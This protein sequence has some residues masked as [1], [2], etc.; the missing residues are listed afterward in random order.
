MNG[1]HALRESTDRVDLAIG[2]MTCASCAA[3]V[4][5]ALG[6]VPG[7]DECSVNFATETATVHY[8]PDAVDPAALRDAVVGIGYSAAVPDHDHHAPGITGGE[9]AE[10]LHADDARDLLRRLV[11]AVVLTVPTVLIS[12]VPALMFDGWQWVAG[13]LATPVVF[14]CGWPYHRATWKHLRHGAVTMDTLV[15]VGTLS[16]WTWS[17]VALLFLGAGSDSSSGMAGM[18]GTA[19]SGSDAHVYFETAAAITALLLL[20]RWFEARAKRRS[21]E[22][23]RAL[24]ELGAKTA[25]LESGEEIPVA[26]LQVGQRFVV[27]PGEK[28]AT[29]GTV[30]TGSSAVDVSMLTGESVPEEVTEGD[31]VFGA[32]VNRS[33]RLVVEATSVGADT[34]LAQ[35]ARLVAEA[36]GS[37]A[38]VQRLADRVSAVFVPVVLVLAV[39]TLLGWLVTGHAAS[40]AFTAAVAVLII[41]CPCALGLATPTAIMVGTGR[42][43]QLGILIKG[44][45]VLETSR[46]IDIAVLDKTGTITTGRMTLVGK[47]YADGADPV[48][49][50]ALIAAAEDASEHP[51]AR[52]VVAGLRTDAPLATPTAVASTPG[53]G[54]AATVD[55]AAVRV[56]RADHVPPVPADLAAAADAGAARGETPVFGAVDGTTVAVFLVADTPK[57]HSREAVASL[58]A[59]GVETVML[60]GDRRATAEAVARDVGVDRVI[61]EV[62]P[63]GKVATVA[64][65]QAAGRRVAMVGDG[66][67][68][69]PALAQSDLG[70]AIGAGTDVAI[71]AGDVT[72]V[73]GDLR[74]VPDAIAL[75]R[76]TL[77]TI[78]GNLFWAFAYN[79]AA[80]PLAAFGLL[81]PVIAAAAMGFSSVFVVTNSL[82]LRRFR[83]AR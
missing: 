17:V 22:A 13:V 43:A 48:R 53:L 57:E 46:L 66:V 35:I 18:A 60:T 47:R 42:G 77:R 10:H 52:A 31:E 62:L 70:I 44:G 63:A 38:P 41:A 21:S 75:S 27:R 80:I 79:V 6:G 34:A 49:T 82:R 8:H 71:E 65:L 83:G 45:E 9:H 73:S 37:K 58:R 24:V 67:N 28:I 3:R 68:D 7:V 30:V 33:G 36:Q 26:D 4:E 25:R 50:A 23:L 20:G 74:G 5:K 54:I 1:N 32:T 61:A 29:D 78:K 14:W 81:N 69:A 2:G 72:L 56:G 64:E 76:A 11:V 40:E 55:G 39:V 15:T 59:L 16:A 12:M 19:S 51:V